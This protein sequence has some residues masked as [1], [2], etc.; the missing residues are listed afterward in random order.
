MC[1]GWHRG[2]DVPFGMHQSRGSGLSHTTFI[3]CL[4]N[5]TPLSTT[6][7][8]GTLVL[9]GSHKLD[10]DVGELAEMAKQDPSITHTVVGP[11]GSVLVFGETLLHATGELCDDSE[12]SILTSAYGPPMFP[13]WDDGVLQ[14][15]RKPQDGW[16][17]SPN[18]K[19]SIPQGG[20][21]ETLLTG[22]R[23]WNRR[24]ME[25]QSLITPRDQVLD[26]VAHL[27]LPRWPLVKR[28]VGAK[29]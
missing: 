11:A 12:R 21:L 25:R 19:A 6:D 15:D 5:L 14:D 26:G 2:Q 20:K 29:L 27:R 10:L 13:Y 28:C 4:T 1:V 24:S 18:F 16:V 9:P 3:K 8:G 7:S 17:L 23:H 22:R